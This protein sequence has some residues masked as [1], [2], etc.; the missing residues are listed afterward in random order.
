M[1]RAG[2]H[3]W[4]AL[5]IGLALLVV[6]SWAISGIKLNLERIIR[7]VGQAASI[8]S[9][10]F[11]RPGP[12]WTYLPTVLDGLLESFLMA[13]WGTTIAAILA[14]P[15]GVLAAK[16][17]GRAMSGPAKTVLNAIRTFPEL[18]LAIVFMRGVGPGAFA[19][20]L[21]IGFHSV[22]MLGKLYAEVIEAVDPSPVEALQAAGASRLLT[23]WYAIVPQILP[24]FLSYG[25]YR[26]EINM[27]A[28]TVVGLVGAGGIGSS[29][30]FQLLAWEW[31]RVGLILLGVVIAVGVLDAIS[32]ALRSR[33]V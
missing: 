12:D 21:A 31:P 1:G 30:V 15:I 17:A 14:V 24:D 27:R 13:M 5:A 2:L 33:L 19:G 7:G 6:Y 16:N 18:L 8:I 25:L 29:L 26:L 28:S 10:M 3:R 23:F 9:Q 4:R 32:G 20:I 22:G 11:F